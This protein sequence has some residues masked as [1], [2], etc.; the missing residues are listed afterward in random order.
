MMFAA[1]SLIAFNGEA[2]AAVC[3]PWSSPPCTRWVTQMDFRWILR[4]E[5]H[6]GETDII[7]R[8]HSTVDEIQ[9]FQ[10]NN[11]AFIATMNSTINP[12]L[13][14]EQRAYEGFFEKV[15]QVMRSFYIVSSDPTL[16]VS[17]LKQPTF[18]SLF[19]S[20]MKSKPSMPSRD[21]YSTVQIYEPRCAACNYGPAIVSML[22]FNVTMGK[23]KFVY[24]SNSSAPIGVGF[25]PTCSKT[26]ICKMDAEMHCI[27]PDG[28]KNCAVCLDPLN[29]KDIVGKDINIF[30]TYYGTDTKEHRMMSGSSNP[31]NFR[32]L[33]MDAVYNKI[34]KD[35][36]LLGET[37]KSLN[38]F[39]D[40]VPNN[41]MEG[42]GRA[43]TRQPHIVTV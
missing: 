36:G 11:T 31:L 14:R 13:F 39:T 27:G 9:R 22:V 34:S 17:Y 26:N 4:M 8:Y 18:L 1:L 32:E 29:P 10:L 43:S 30:T 33:A 12:L 23:G 41:V 16:T 15:L 38:P 7:Y 20:G 35:L 21:H 24:Q 5:E 42:K 3:M 2:C 37:I 19:G 40:E 28:H 25:H 6:E